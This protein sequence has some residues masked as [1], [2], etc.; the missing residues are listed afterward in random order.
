MVGDRFDGPTRASD[1]PV[2]S[3]T[4]PP[5]GDAR[6][7]NAAL[8]A[9]PSAHLASCPRTRA[10][11]VPRVLADVPVARARERKRCGTTTPRAARHNDGSGIVP[12]DDANAAGF[13]DVSASEADQAAPKLI[14]THPNI[15][16][17]T[18]RPGVRYRRIPRD[19]TSDAVVRFA[20]VSEEGA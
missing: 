11:H 1:P 7:R 14:P 16:G 18:L 17:I 10:G 12:R 19:R 4:L 2:P 9:R 20:D 5:G 15:A 3:T 8:K 13:A 6:N